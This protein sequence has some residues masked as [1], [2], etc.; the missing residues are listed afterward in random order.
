MSG[1]DSAFIRAYRKQANRSAER[2]E[3][4]DRSGVGTD[5]RTVRSEPPVE[6]SAG[7]SYA[8]AV[9]LASA[10]RPQLQVDRFQWPEITRSLSESAQ[11]EFSELVHEIEARVASGPKILPWLCAKQGEGCTTLM[12]TM[13]RLLALADCRTI[14]VDANFAR[15]GVATGL[16]IE[17]EV[18]LREVVEGALPLVEAVIESE[19][20]RMSLLPLVAPTAPD[21][22]AWRPIVR[23]TWSTLRRHY[24]LVLVDGGSLDGVGRWLPAILKASGIDG[25][26]LVRDIRVTSQ[27][28]LAESIQDLAGW[29]VIPYGVAENFVPA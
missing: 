20:D 1:L 19:A 6:P 13:A 17:P 18:G 11:G 28:D 4:P 22:E 14:L 10:F 8:S 26:I 7:P 9:P 2:D 15:P 23:E 29:G 21:V 16:G 24:D 27:Q 25:A 5:A 3:E 12:L